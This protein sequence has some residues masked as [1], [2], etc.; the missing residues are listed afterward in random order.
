LDGRDRAEDSPP[1]SA[2]Y[3]PHPKHFSPN[4]LK[5]EQKEATERIVIGGGDEFS[6]PSPLTFHVPLL[7][8][9]A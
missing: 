6:R 8:R 3:V 1:L 2:Y 4:A 9:P 5:S 7:P